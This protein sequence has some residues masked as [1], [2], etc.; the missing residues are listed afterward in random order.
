MNQWLGH[1][2]LTDGGW[3][4]G[5]TLCNP[6]GINGMATIDNPTLK[7]ARQ[8]VKMRSP[9]ENRWKEPAIADLMADIPENYRKPFEDLMAGIEEYEE[10][11]RS[12]IWYGVSWKWT[13]HYEFIDAAG[14]PIRTLGYVVPRHEQPVVC[15]PMSADQVLSLPIRRLNR[16]IRDNIK[17]AKCALETHWAMW[18]PNNNTEIGHILDLVKRLHK[19]EFN[20]PAPKK[21]KSNGKK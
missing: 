3:Q 9:W 14:N 1:T 11:Q 5:W 20:P 4:P 2:A 8:A 10:V 16:A 17:G 13:I 18:N 12:M 21:G 7:Q 6:F 15:L 19:F